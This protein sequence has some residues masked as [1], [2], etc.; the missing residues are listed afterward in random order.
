M[1][2][3][4]GSLTRPIRPEETELATLRMLTTETTPDLSRSESAI[5]VHKIRTTALNW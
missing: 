1:I 4:A 3:Q 5:G 2:L